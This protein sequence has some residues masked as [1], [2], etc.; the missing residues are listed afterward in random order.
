MNID[1]FFERVKNKK[2]SSLAKATESKTSLL[3]NEALFQIPFIAVSILMLSKQ[4]S[5][6]STTDISQVLGECFEFC[7]NGY[8]DSPQQIG[9]SAN[10]RI[11]TANA[12]G[13]LELVGL[14]EIEIES[15]KIKATD[16]GQQVIGAALSQES[17]LQ[18]A[19]NK[20]SRAYNNLRK[21]NQIRLGLQ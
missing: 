5:K 12:I 20:I 6:P 15:K 7:L 21:E 8:K 4:R 14:V 3:P 2:I 9:W 11:R 13:F 10:L 17:S 16:L 19:L 1:E 18:I